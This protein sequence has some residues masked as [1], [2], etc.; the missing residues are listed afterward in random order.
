MDKYA[1]LFRLFTELTFYVI[2][3]YLKVVCFF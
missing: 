2:L 3:F 1:H